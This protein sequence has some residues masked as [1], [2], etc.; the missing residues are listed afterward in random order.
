M[1]ARKIRVLVA[2]GSVVN[3]ERMI[4]LLR[5]DPEIEVVGEVARGTGVVESA[6]RYCPDV[7]A[8][9]INLSA[10]DGFEA[11]KE[12]MIEAPTPV[13]IVSDET[14]VRQVEASILALRAGA[15]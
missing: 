6:R 4:A 5:T 13:V 11:T 7:I 8:L 2:D 9:G 1:A 10:G 12:I 3:R 15:L 14:D